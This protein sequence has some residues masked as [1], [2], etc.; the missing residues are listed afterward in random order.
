MTIRIRKTFKNL[1]LENHALLQENQNLHD[2][3]KKT[4]QIRDDLFGLASH[5]LKTPITSLRSQ[6]ELLKRNSQ[7]EVGLIPGSK[8]LSSTL[9]ASLGQVDRLTKL[10]GN[11]LDVT[12]IGAGKLQLTITS[13]DLVKLVQKVITSFSVELELA[14]C[15]IETHLP[16]VLIGEWDQGC[17][18]QVIVNLIS[19]A[20]K[21]APSTLLSIS[22]FQ[23]ELKTTLKIRDNGPGI[24]K[25][26]QNII[27]NKFECV[28]SSE[29]C[30][31]LGLGLYIC[32]QIIEKH[33]GTI[34]V[35]SEVGKGTEFIIELPNHSGK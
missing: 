15:S 6:L 7:P 23:T 8:H 29:T 31:S 25:N 11:M 34:H 1:E 18:E 17:I 10:I 28:S 22:A 3:L 35:Q 9:E 4:I 30:R 32:S 19:N 24:P 12:R 21:Y 2:H 14:K 5:E 16:D 20:I 26:K 13:V 27:F 33:A